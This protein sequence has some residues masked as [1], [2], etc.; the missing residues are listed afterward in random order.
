TVS[1]PELGT[2]QPRTD[3]RFSNYKYTSLRDGLA[4]FRS[5]SPTKDSTSVSHDDLRVYNDP[6]LDALDRKSYS[7]DVGLNTLGLDRTSPRKFNPSPERLNNSN[8]DAGESPVGTPR[9]GQKVAEKR[10]QS[11]GPRSREVTKSAPWDI[12]K[13]YYSY[14]YQQPVKNLVE[15]Y[16]GLNLKN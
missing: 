8:R 2:D 3:Y 7:I 1:E 13:R 9:R 6:E 12:E 15:K 4:K 5:P 16:Q 10:S 11:S 14:R